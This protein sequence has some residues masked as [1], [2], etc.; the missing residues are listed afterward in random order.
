MSEFIGECLEGPQGCQGEV[1]EYLAL[2]GSGELYPRCEHH[3]ELYVERLQPQIDAINR[4]YPVT[5]PADFDPTYANEA[6]DED[7]W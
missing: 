7:D 5:A 2:S 4:R 6:W 1:S 3:Y